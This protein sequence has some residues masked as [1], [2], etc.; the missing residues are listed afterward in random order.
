MSNAYNKGKRK[1][2]AA[3]NNAQWDGK[4]ADTAVNDARR[5]RERELQQQEDERI[6]VSLK[7]NATK[8]RM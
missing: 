5:Q 2:V 1:A 6:D 7:Y 4:R 3:N 8:Q